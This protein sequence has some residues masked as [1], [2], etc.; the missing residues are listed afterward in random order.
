VNVVYV[1]RSNPIPFPGSFSEAL[2]RKIDRVELA[3]G[4]AEAVFHG[5]TLLGTYAAQTD[6]GVGRKQP[7]NQ[8]SVLIGQDLDGR[9]YLVSIDGMGGMDAGEIASREI[10]QSLAQDLSSGVHLRE[11]IKFSEH[12]L[13]GFNQAQLL[14]DPNPITKNM[15]ATL[16]AVEIAGNRARVYHIGD[17]RALILR[18]GNIIY[19]TH[20]HSQIQREIDG[21]KITREDALVSDLR[22]AVDRGLGLRRGWP[23]ESQ[24]DRTSIELKSGDI[25]VLASDGLWDVLL[26]EKVAEIVVKSGHPYA[27]VAT[28]REKVRL[29]V[30]R[31]HELIEVENNPHL[32]ADDNINIIIYQHK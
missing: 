6:K 31:R 19:E 15:A 5:E 14:D 17:S 13:F 4:G 3:C 30:D 28:L 2:A 11:A 23:M 22:Y 27:G 12:V 7:V 9:T 26:S 21:G 10:A 18:D 16:V 32:E 1:T 20:D 8:D 24:V 25:L 29:E